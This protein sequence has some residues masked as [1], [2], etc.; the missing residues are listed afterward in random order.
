[1]K[2]SKWWMLLPVTVAIAL[3]G[4]FYVL[5]PERFMVDRT[6]LLSILLVAGATAALV[7]SLIS[8]GGRNPD[9]SGV[10]GMIGIETLLSGFLLVSASVGVALAISGIVK[11]AMALNIVTLAGFVAMLVVALAMAS[12]TPGRASG[13][14][15][16]SNHLLWAERLESIAGGC[17]IP[18]LKPRLL[19]LAGETRFLA[20]DDGRGV[21][22]VNQRI[23]SVLDTVA[24]SVKKGDT[25]GAMIQLK[26]LRN[27]FSE[28]ET[29]LM[30]LKRPV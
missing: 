28:R 9:Q 25:Q 30:N 26:R 17:R 5:F 22:E 8:G 6:L 23:A 19:K 7:S 11:A 27:L 21:V 4:V 20:Q 3:I 2:N 18:Q 16:R 10:L 15:T 24:E 12:A 13:R 1:M 29:E 14:K